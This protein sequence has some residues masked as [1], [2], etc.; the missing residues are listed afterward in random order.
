MSGNIRLPGSGLVLDLVELLLLILIREEAL[1]F[2]DPTVDAEWIGGSGNK[3]SS[4]S[5]STT[6]CSSKRL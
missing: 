3:S 6:C 1:L 4:A 2:C 5:E